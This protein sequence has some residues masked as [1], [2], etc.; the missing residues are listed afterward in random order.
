[1]KHGYFPKFEDFSCIYFVCE[2]IENYNLCFGLQ[3]NRSDSDSSMPLY[4]RAG[5]PFQRGSVERRSLRWAGRRPRGMAAPRGPRT[6]LDLELDLRAQ[7]TRQQALQ[8]ELVRLRELKARLETAREHGDTE[9]A[10]WVLEDTQFQN[11]VAQVNK[12]NNYIVM[13]G[14]KL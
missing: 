2:S 1:M 7:K 6:S 11:L 4:R 3:L 10:A 5:G 8:D 14:G 9:I 12:I 13:S